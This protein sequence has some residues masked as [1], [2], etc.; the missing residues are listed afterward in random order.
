MVT[1]ICLMKNVI[2]P[3]G[4]YTSYRGFF[5][6]SFSLAHKMFVC[7]GN[8]L[9]LNELGGKGKHAIHRR[10]VWVNKESFLSHSAPS[11]CEVNWQF[12]D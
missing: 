5:F 11:E 6:L 3:K 2:Y 10:S 8:R 12:T 1:Q 9:M 7:Y 4:T